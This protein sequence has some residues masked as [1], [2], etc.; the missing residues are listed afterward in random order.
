MLGAVTAT[1]FLS[2][3]TQKKSNDVILGGE[4]KL[5]TSVGENTL[6]QHN[7]ARTVDGR[8]FF[9]P[10][11]T[12]EDSWILFFFSVSSSH[13]T[14][15][16]ILLSLRYNIIPLYLNLA[17]INLHKMVK[18]KIPLITSSVTHNTLC[19][20]LGTDNANSGEKFEW[21]LSEVLQKKAANA[22]Y[23]ILTTCV[24]HK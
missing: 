14:H 21:F 17:T 3:H 13:T 1:N 2:S 18:R 11:H 23:F 19:Y 15:A 8:K 9:S 20:T 5:Q 16:Q 10:Q 7:S 22:K 12:M 6:C 4:K 24:Y